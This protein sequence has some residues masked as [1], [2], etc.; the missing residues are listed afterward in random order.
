MRLYTSSLLPVTFIMLL[1]AR[2]T[3]TDKTTANLLMMPRTVIRVTTLV[4]SLLRHFLIDN[5]LNH[6]IDFSRTSHHADPHST[7]VNPREASSAHIIVACLSWMFVV[8]L[9]LILG[10]FLQFLSL[11]DDVKMGIVKTL[12][13]KNL[14]D[15]VTCVMLRSVVW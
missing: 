3:R 5:A 13:W 10:W 9:S 7:L 1:Y 2:T 4:A 12:I 11:I 6:W 8:L 14:T 15:W